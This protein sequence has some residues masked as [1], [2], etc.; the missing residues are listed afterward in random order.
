MVGLGGDVVHRGVADVHR[1]VGNE[2]LLGLEHQAVD[3]VHPAVELGVYLVELGVF[4]HADGAGAPR[5]G[6]ARWGRPC[7]RPAAGGGGSRGQN[8]P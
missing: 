8:G 4:V 6:G 1:G 3:V 5:G 2:H 7:A